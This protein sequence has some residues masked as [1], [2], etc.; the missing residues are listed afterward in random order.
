MTSAPGQRIP[1]PPAPRQP[2]SV[3]RVVARARRDHPQR[4]TAARD[5]L[6]RQVHHAVAAG[7]D[8]ARHTAGNRRSRLIGGFVGAPPDQQP[9][10]VPVSAQP[11]AHRPGD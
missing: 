5:R 11:I 3:R 4:G 1:K 6:Q 8:H 10:L 9:H 7:G 2:E